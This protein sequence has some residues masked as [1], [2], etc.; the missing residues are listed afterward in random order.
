MVNP[1]AAGDKILPVQN[2][3]KNLKND[4]NPGKWVIIGEYSARA[5]Q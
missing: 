4:S 1:Y 3:A 5:I 2:D